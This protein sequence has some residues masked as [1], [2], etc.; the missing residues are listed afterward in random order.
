[1]QSLAGPR[2][3]LCWPDGKTVSPCERP[4]SHAGLGMG[5]KTAVVSQPFCNPICPN[6]ESEQD[7][8]WSFCL[9]AGTLC[10]ANQERQ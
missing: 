5:Q 4:A 6:R 1:M 3:S 2:N 9:T 7:D 8:K 10:P